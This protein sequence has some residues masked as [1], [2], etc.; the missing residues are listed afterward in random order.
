MTKIQT[1]WFGYVL[2]KV[3]ARYEII[4]ETLTDR[5]TINI[6]GNPIIVKDYKR[7][8]WS[9]F[10]PGVALSQSYKTKEEC[11]NYQKEYHLCLST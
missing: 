7:V 10:T 3:N 6:F 4:E 11:E 2:E 5:L 8:A 9:R 1:Y